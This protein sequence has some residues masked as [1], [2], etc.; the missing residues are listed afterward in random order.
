M[1]LAFSSSLHHASS[2]SESTLPITSTHS[3]RK[4]Q[5]SSHDSKDS[6]VTKE[7]NI[8]LNY[9]NQPLLSIGV[10]A[11]IQHAPVP[12]GA[13]FSGTPRYYKY[14]LEVAGVAAK[15]FQEAKVDLLV[16][17]GDIIDGKCALTS[18]TIDMNE[19]ERENIVGKVAMKNVINALNAYKN[20]PIIHTYGNH[21]LY[22]LSREDI[23]KMLCI[24]FVQETKADLVGYRSIVKNQ[25]RFIV[26]DTYDVAI[27]GRCPDKSE[28]R[29]QAER[30]LAQNNPNFPENENSPE[31]MTGLQKR[32]VAFNGGIGATQLSWLRSTLQ[33][34]EKNGELVIILSHQPIHPQSSS[35]VCLIWNYEEVLDILREFE[36]TVIASFSGHAHRGGYHRDETSGIHFRVFEAVLESP[37]PINTY[38]FVDI[39]ENKIHVRGEGKCESARYDFK[40]L[41]STS[42]PQNNV[43]L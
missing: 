30:I 16:N 26:L 32:F 8:K 11:D 28:K 7:K 19:D 38:A 10:V 9:K 21:E 22:N 6:S 35:P 25:V 23:G 31:N 4:T 36:S 5:V 34:A 15:H 3:N 1:P 42:V 17:L 37:Y 24:P 43:S 18:D 2:S 27:M 13:S 12:D 33:E 14:A 40:H 29:K 41:A 39:Y 20:G